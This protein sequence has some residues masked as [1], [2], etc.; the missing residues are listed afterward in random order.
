MEAEAGAWRLHLDALYGQLLDL[1]QAENERRAMLQDL[2]DRLDSLEANVAQL[3]GDVSDLKNYTA[4][5]KS[6]AGEILELLRESGRPN[7]QHIP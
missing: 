7:R 2:G 3:A 6:S 5:L 4:G 1:K